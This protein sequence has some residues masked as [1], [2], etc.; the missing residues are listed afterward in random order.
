MQV[1]SIS[2]RLRELTWWHTCDRLHGDIYMTTFG[3][4]RPY[5]LYI[6]RENFLVKIHVYFKHLNDFKICQNVFGCL[7][8]QTVQLFCAKNLPFKKKYILLFYSLVIYIYI[9]SSYFLPFRNFLR[10]WCHMNFNQTATY[11]SKFENNRKNTLQHSGT[12]I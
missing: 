1:G 12:Q 5:Q 6:A 3:N 9:Y 2:E 4:R 8:N 10:C 7:I 11:S